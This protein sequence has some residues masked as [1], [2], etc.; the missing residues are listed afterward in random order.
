LLD[1][2]NRGR[3]AIVMEDDRFLG[4]TRTDFAVLSPAPHAEIGYATGTRVRLIAIW[5][6]GKTG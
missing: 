6:P 1:V 5:N 3:I 2:F 4:C